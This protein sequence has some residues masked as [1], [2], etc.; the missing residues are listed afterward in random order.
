MF[1]LS[2][3]EDT[4][5]GLRLAGICGA[6]VKNNEDFDRYCQS[7]LQDE[8]TGILLVTRSLA[9]E[10]PKKLLEIKKAGKLLV[11]EVP[12]IYAGESENSS[13]TNYIRDAV[14]VVG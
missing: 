8:E 4:L 9:R 1:L 6:M 2:S 12:D 7:A 13:I 5:T 3:D 11:T 14:G 10:Y